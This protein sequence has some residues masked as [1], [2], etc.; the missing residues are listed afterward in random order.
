M[1]TQYSGQ[2]GLNQGVFNSYGRNKNWVTSFNCRIRGHYSDACSNLPLTS[3][4]QQH[5]R[6]RIRW[7][8][9]LTELEFQTL[10]CDPEPTLG[11][12]HRVEITPRGILRW[13]LPETTSTLAATSLPVACVRLCSVSRRD[14]ANAC[15]VTTRI[16]AV[17]TIFENALTEK[18]AWVEE[19]EVESDSGQRAT[20]VLCRMREL[21][22]GSEPRRSLRP[23]NNTLAYPKE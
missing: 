7:E 22:E 8:R 16:P 20:K 4:K 18:R 12:A 1:G 14:F 15:V 6:C 17:G 2:R 5:F 9:E 21:G 23:T 10:Q 3:Y 11:G 19:G 13:Q